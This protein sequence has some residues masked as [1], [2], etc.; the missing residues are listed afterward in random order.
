VICHRVQDSFFILG[1]CV[2]FSPFRICYVG[3][4]VQVIL[5]SIC[6]LI[7]FCGEIIMYV[8]Y[9]VSCVG[10][11]LLSAIGYCGCSCFMVLLV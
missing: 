6:S 1:V 3:D 5:S 11:S 9:V 10:I 8:V 2:V 7:S 4:C